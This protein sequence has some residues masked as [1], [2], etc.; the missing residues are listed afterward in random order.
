ML[1][2]QTAGQVPRRVPPIR[3]C[4]DVPGPPTDKT[5][6]GPPQPGSLSNQEATANRH[7]TFHR[8]ETGGACPSVRQVLASHL[9]YFKPHAQLCV[10][11]VA[12]W[13]KIKDSQ[14][15]LPVGAPRS[16]PVQSQSQPKPCALDS[17][18]RLLLHSSHWTVLGEGKTRSLR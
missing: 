15:E 18:E 3:L 7:L 6:N 1:W 14:E 5:P 10:E 12:H 8:T 16:K 17:S 13:L 4:P 2:L 11:N 9:P